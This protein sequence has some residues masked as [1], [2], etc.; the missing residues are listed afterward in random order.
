MNIT[1]TETKQYYNHE[2]QMW[3]FEINVTYHHKKY[4]VKWEI[5]KF[6][7]GLI[8]SF[9]NKIYTKERKL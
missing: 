4:V 3:K 7:D 6:K 1:Y 8:R 9:R 5:F 2:V